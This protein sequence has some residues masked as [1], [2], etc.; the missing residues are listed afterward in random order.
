MVRT[1]PGF[2]DVS[3]SPVIPLSVSRTAQ[4]FLGCFLICNVLIF[5]IRMPASFDIYLL[6]ALSEF[7]LHIDD[8]VF[9]AIS[10]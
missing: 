7:Q 2:A 3:P 4:M 6:Q 10:F 9:P 5:V 8:F 1:A